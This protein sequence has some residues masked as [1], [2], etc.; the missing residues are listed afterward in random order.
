MPRESVSTPS[1]APPQPF[2][3][4]SPPAPVV[5]PSK[6]ED[7]APSARERVARAGASRAAPAADAARTESTAR[8][9]DAAR[10]AAGTSVEGRAAPPLAPEE[11][12]RRIREHYDAGR[13]DQAARELRAFRDAYADADVR[14]PPELRAWAATLRK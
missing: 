1:V 14:L 12:V 9:T 5:P 6:Q 7:A 11:F 4:A 3:M 10:A 2:P 13:L 8:A